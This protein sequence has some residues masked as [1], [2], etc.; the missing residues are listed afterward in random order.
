MEVINFET[1]YKPVRWGELEPVDGYELHHEMVNLFVKSGQRIGV[2]SYRRRMEKANEYRERT[3]VQAP[4]KHAKYSPIHNY[5][6]KHLFQFSDG[7]QLHKEEFVF[8][9]DLDLTKVEHLE[10]VPKDMVIK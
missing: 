5:K 4:S 3:S 2:E 6:I 9:L 1:E 8:Y 7:K 10:I